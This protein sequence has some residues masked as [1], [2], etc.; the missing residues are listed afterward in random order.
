MNYVVVEVLELITQISFDM[1]HQ[2]VRLDFIAA[3]D[4]ST[5]NS[6]YTIFFQAMFFNLH[7]ACISGNLVLL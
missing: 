3:N 2:I 6:D 1:D 7:F 5:K 4:L